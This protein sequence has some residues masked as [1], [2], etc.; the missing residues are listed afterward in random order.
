MNEYKSVAFWSWNDNLDKKELHNQIYQFKQAH[1][2]GFII[3]ARGGLEIEYLGNVW[4]D[5]VIEAIKTAKSL[6]M[7]VWLYDEFGWPS[8]T[9]NGLVIDSNSDFK[10]K[11][12][13][14][15]NSRE[16]IDE[17][18]IIVAY[19]KN[20]NQDFIICDFNDNNASMF[21]HYE[22][23]DNYTDLL[24]KEAVKVFIDTT[25]E[26]YKK[27]IGEYFG[28]T[29]KGFFTDE[30]QI[31][32]PFIWSRYIEEEYK[33]KY[34]DIKK[35]LWKLFNT[36]KKYSD[37]R[38]KY[39][40]IIKDLFLKNFTD[41]ISKWCSNNKLQFTGHFPCEDG[42][43]DQYCVTGGVQSNYKLMHLPAI[44]YLGKRLTSP[45][46]IKQISGVKN[47]FKI[48][49]I[50]S[51]TFGATGWEFT[52]EQMKWIWGYQAVL[53]INKA[54]IHLSAYSIRGA[55]KRDY[56]SFFSYQ[57]PWWTE[58]CYL[59]KWINNINK[60]MSKGNSCSNILVLSPLSSMYIYPYNSL[61]Q[62]QISNQFRILIDSLLDLQID[63]DIV[64]EWI[65]KN[66]GELINNKI[67]VG[68]KKYD[69]M[70]ISECDNLLQSSVELFMNIENNIFFINEVPKYIDGILNEVVL[71]KLGS[72]IIQNRF[73]ILNKFF[74]KINYQRK[75]ETYPALNKLK[76]NNDILLNIRKYKDQY[77]VMVFN[78]CRDSSK[79]VFLSILGDYDIY[80]INI[81][82]LEETKLKSINNNH[83]SITK[84][85]LQ[86]MESSIYLFKRCTNSSNSIKNLEKITII[87]PKDLK[88]LEDNLFVIDKARFKYNNDKLSE[89]IQ[90][91]D[92]FD[93]ISK[94][95]NY[96]DTQFNISIFYEF[97]LETIP[98]SLEFIVETEKIRKIL[99]NNKKVEVNKRSWFIDKSFKKVDIINFI[100]LGKNII[101]LKYLIEKETFIKSNN[102]T[103]EI[104]KNKE[105]HFYEFENVILK[106]NFD[107]KPKKYIELEMGYRVISPDFK[108]KSP[109]KKTLIKELTA[110]GLWSYRGSIQFDFEV[111]YNNESSIIVEIDKINIACLYLV[112]NGQKIYEKKNNLF[113]I[114]K[115]LKP[116][117]NQVSIY[118]IISNRNLFGPHH[119]ISNELILTGPTS[120]TGD[121]TYLDRLS[122]VN[123]RKNTKC[124][125]YYFEK[126]KIESIFIKY[127]K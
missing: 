123:D 52:F 2:G 119:H 4:F 127:Y 93:K 108:I 41:Q 58:F 50:M 111:S 97:Y 126:N 71:K 67:I 84:I 89:E 109:S 116:G 81:N 70:I 95:I 79:S 51:E 121:F 20:F 125:Y 104:T 96:N 115:F 76:R 77:L 29:V 28:N 33:Q 23:E 1:Y 15:S 82:S 47:Q 11:V 57:Q 45:V 68:D 25:H 3:H 74:I 73:D 86:A 88:L 44:D 65:L 94:S 49:T 53:G 31:K 5:C 63:F 62:Q 92:L 32:I 110:Q 114:T 38:F 75:I 101:E 39:Y 87:K 48:P 30:P 64:D 35:D 107:I 42:L 6:N 56:P 16:S 80:E 61:R 43:I 66:H 91:I 99:F 34:G 83:Q 17:S 18:Q 105:V 26:V 55:R 9:S 100:K 37:F 40:N 103:H 54:C 102:H 112:I 21:I 13:K 78:K 19:K 69:F 72:N 46:L 90:V 14:F 60:L 120:Y 122:L 7:D 85:N 113:D 117:I 8:G 10:Q 36:D 118:L 24:N 22:I 106:G 27:E 12:L 124:K 98:D 59:N